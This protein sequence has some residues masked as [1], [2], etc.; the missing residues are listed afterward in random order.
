MQAP[1]DATGMIN[2]RLMTAGVTV[3]ELS[4]RE[5]TLEDVFFLMTESDTP[6]RPTA[7]TGDPV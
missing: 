4:Q 1:A 3:N 6:A 5:R 2:Q 7:T